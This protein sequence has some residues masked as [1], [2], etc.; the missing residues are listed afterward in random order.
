[1]CIF[2]TMKKIYF[3]ISILVSFTLLSCEINDYVEPKALPEPT[4]EGRQTF[5]V[6]INGNLWTPFQKY[7]VNPNFKPAP[8]V[9]GKLQQQTLRIAVTNQ[10]TLESISL[11]I[12]GVNG[13]GEYKFMTYYPKNALEFSPFASLYQR[14][15]NG[16][17]SQYV[18]CNTCDNQ[19]NL[20]HFDT[21][22]KIFSGTFSV[23]FQ[24]KD[25]PLETIT[26][27]DGRFDIKD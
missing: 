6:K 7:R 19:V 13:I 11:M 14:C 26:L 16:N 12:N 4:Q 22:R 10:E 3:I 18:I 24:K 15:I 2:D 1:M 27:S 17:C 8:V 21:T 23:T 5:G 20:T 9:W 25:H